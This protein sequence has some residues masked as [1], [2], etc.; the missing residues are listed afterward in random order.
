MTY[1]PTST[2]SDDQYYASL[3]EQQMLE[4]E[5]QYEAHEAM[6]EAQAEEAEEA[7]EGILSEEEA[8]KLINDYIRSDWSGH[9]MDQIPF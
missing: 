2:N 5:A 4:W 3:Y 6:Q 9:R 8:E 7:E 1:N